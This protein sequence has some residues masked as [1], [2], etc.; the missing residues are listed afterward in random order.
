MRILLDE[1]LPKRLKQ[2]FPE[3]EVYTV[4]EREWNGLKNGELLKKLLEN[5]FQVLITFDKKLEYQQN[6]SRFQ[7]TVLTIKAIDNT[8]LTLKE[9]V[10]AIKRTLKEKLKPGITVID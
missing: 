1:N 2:N 8:Y 5:D 9:L 3:H 10:P 6:F 7:I 4:R